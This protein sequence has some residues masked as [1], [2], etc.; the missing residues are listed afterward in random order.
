MMMTPHMSPP[1]EGHHPQHPRT[2]RNQS[3]KVVPNVLI[4]SQSDEEDTL[5]GSPT[6]SISG[7]ES[8]TAYGS[9]T[10]SSTHGRAISRKVPVPPNIDP[11]PVAEEPNRWYVEGQ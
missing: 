8:H 9:A 3:K 5:I 2:T 11:T 7:S 1:L 6:G 10:S 4:A